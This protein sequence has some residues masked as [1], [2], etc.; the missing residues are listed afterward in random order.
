MRLRVGNTNAT[1]IVCSTHRVDRSVTITYVGK[2]NWN[3]NYL[4]GSIAGL[5]AVDALLTEAEIATVIARINAGEDT[6]Q[7]CGACPDDGFEPGTGKVSAR[8]SCQFCPLHSDPLQGIT[9]INGCQ[10][11][12]GYSGVD[13]VAC[14]ACGE[15]TYKPLPGPVCTLCPDHSTSARGRLSLVDCKCKAGY[16]GA[17]G[18]T[19]SPCPVDTYKDEVGSAL[20][21]RCR[22]NFA[23]AAGST[24]VDACACDASFLYVSAINSRAMALVLV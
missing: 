5:Y 14:S 24:S 15:G 10:C 8:S 18:G 9:N 19:C 11:S 16:T 17:D 12:A 13:G 22:P 20:C 1:P 21:T 6:L 23:S 4:S 2:D 3:T 7:S